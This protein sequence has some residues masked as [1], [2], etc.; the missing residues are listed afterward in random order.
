MEPT[1]LHANHFARLSGGRLLL[2]S[3]T[4]FLREITVVLLV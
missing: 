1:R 2:D 3:V 4:Y